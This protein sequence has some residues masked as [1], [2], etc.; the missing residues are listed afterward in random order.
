M[1]R[2]MLCRNPFVITFLLLLLGL[3]SGCVGEERRNGKAMPKKEVK[4]TLVEANK[5]L[6]KTEE[7]HIKDLISRYGWDMEETGTGLR[8]MI[9]EEGN[10]PTI[11][12]GDVVELEY[13]VRLIT[14]DRI[15][16]SDEEGILM[17]VVGKAEVISGLEQGILLLRV[18]DKAK[19]VIPSHLAYGLLGD[20]HKIPTKATLIYDIQVIRKK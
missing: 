14:G 17:F 20:D 13:E 10:G 9:Y 8:Y 2:D 16:S 3:I 18:G 12:T 15:Y 1:L 19:F 5:Q 6:V 4:E 11:V 7:Q